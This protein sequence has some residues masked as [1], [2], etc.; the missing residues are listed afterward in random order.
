VKVDL[1]LRQK[2]KSEGQRPVVRCQRHV[3]VGSRDG[4][5]RRPK[6]DGAD[7][8]AL[9]HFEHLMYNT[10]DT[11]GVTIF[12]QQPWQFGRGGGVKA[13]VTDDEFEIPV[14]TPSAMSSRPTAG[15]T[16]VPTRP[17]AM[18]ETSPLAP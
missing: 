6:A 13:V 8:A 7:C 17:L 4:R 3:A 18:P 5:P 2:R 10:G 14:E 9:A 16:T 11:R 15:L 1:I 12:R